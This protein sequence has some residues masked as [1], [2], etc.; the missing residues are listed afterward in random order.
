[1]RGLSALTGF[2]LICVLVLTVAIVQAEQ[3]GEPFC[4]RTDPSKYREVNYGGGSIYEM[5]ILEGEIMGTNVLYMIR[6]IIPARAG[7]GEHTHHN[8]EEMYFVFN[9]PAEFTLDG[10]TTL[11]PP[12]QVYCVHSVHPMRCT[13]TPTRRSSI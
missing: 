13:I 2:I 12:G 4:G 7:I 9:A 5:T 8:I 11:L 10:H 3:K 1:M 6:G